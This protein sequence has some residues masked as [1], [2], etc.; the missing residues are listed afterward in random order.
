MGEVLLPVGF[1][2]GPHYTPTGQPE[3]ADWQIGVGTGTVHPPW[4]A[5]TLWA[6]AFGALPVEQLQ[7]AAGAAGL[8]DTGAAMEELRHEGL[9]L[10]LDPAWPTVRLLELFDRL[11]LHPRGVG[12]GNPAPDRSVYRIRSQRG[13]VEVTCGIDEYWAYFGS[14]HR[15]LGE[16]LRT[17]AD[18][19]TEYASG[20]VAELVCRAVEGGLLY[21][22]WHEQPVPDPATGTDR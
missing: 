7:F 17:T 13:D 2:I 14:R 12:Y 22:D 1:P 10:A 19:W 16:Q 21:L 20:A 5:Y 11:H 8:G 9:L 4:P 6:L 18:G 15:T 3:N